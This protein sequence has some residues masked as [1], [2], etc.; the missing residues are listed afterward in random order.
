NWF[1]KGGNASF[2]RVGFGGLQGDVVNFPWRRTATFSGTV[3]FSNDGCTAGLDRDPHFSDIDGDK[4]A[5]IFSGQHA[6]RFHR[7]SVP[8]IKPEDAVGL[9]DR[10]PTFDIGEF[11]AINLAHADLPAIQFSP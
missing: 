9:R 4:G 10:E 8:A 5:A 1:D 6:A 2:G 3:S 11:P 7:L